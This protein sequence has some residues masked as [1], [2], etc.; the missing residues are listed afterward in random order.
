MK[1]LVFCIYRLNAIS[2]PACT[3]LCY[4]LS[5][6]FHR[7]HSQ[8]STSPSVSVTP[9]FGCPSRRARSVNRKSHPPLLI[10]FLP[11][12][13]SVCC[14]P[15]DW[16][17]YYLQKMSKVCG[18]LK[19]IACVFE[20]TPWHVMLEGIKIR[21]KHSWLSILWIYLLFVLFTQRYFK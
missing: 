12:S 4:L 11:S 5:S 18:H 9:T 21:N 15:K 6:L 3:S 8:A 16:T 13:R 14:P 2:W 1:Y 19:Q 7:L 10:K 17:P 20:H